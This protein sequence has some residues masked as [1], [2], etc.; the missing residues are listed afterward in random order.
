MVLGGE[1]GGEVVL[2]LPDSLDEVGCDADVEGAVG[3]G[4]EDVDAGLHGVRIGRGWGGWQGVFVM[5]GWGVRGFPPARERREGG[6]G[7]DGGGG[8][9]EKRGGDGETLFVAGELQFVSG[10]GLIGLMVVAGS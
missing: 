8:N 10:R 6:C 4:C 1:A 2:V 5:G 3:A 7:N 9:D